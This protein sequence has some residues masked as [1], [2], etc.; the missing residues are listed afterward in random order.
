MKKKAVRRPEG[1][2]PPQNQVRRKKKGVRRPEGQRPE[3]HARGSDDAKSPRPQGAKETRVQ[4]VDGKVWVAKQYRA[5]RILK[6]DS[7]SEETIP[8]RA[9]PASVKLG[10]VTV[11]GGLTQNLGDFN[12]AR[13]DVGVTLPCAV[14]ELDDA[15]EA[16]I[17]FASQRLDELSNDLK[18]DDD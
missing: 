10:S 1:G 15:Y 17:A 2:T 14:E 7:S 18:R 8:I 5:G 16:A 13:F 9:Y 6:E 11:S 12:S 3:S 4:S